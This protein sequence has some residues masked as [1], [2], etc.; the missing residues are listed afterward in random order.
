MNVQCVGSWGNF[1]D[2][3]MSPHLDKA[4]Q[5]FDNLIMWD[6]LYSGR[7][8]GKDPDAGKDWGQ[9]EKGMTEDEMVG[10]HHWHN[11]YEFEQT[12][13][14][15]EG[16]GSLVCC[17]PWG[18][19]ESD[20][21]SDWTATATTLVGGLPLPGKGALVAKNSPAN[22]GDAGLI[23]GLEDP[24]EEE[25]AP[26]SSILAWKIPWAEEP[27]GLQS[28]GS[29]ESDMT[30]WDTHTHTHTHTHTPP[31]GKGYEF[32][33][34]RYTQFLVIKLSFL[35][36][37]PKP[38]PLPQNTQNEYLTFT[39]IASYQKN[40]FMVQ[41]IL[42]RVYDLMVFSSHILHCP[43]IASLREHWDYFLERTAK[44]PN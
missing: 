21:S 17:S 33:K 6:P 44:V 24:L 10:W 30:E 20:R 9:E 23:P 29:K 27:G 42:Q 18:Q 15:S 7:F 36:I 25:V 22:E 43:G 1:W 26:H 39:D 4:N 16:Q 28:M 38:V 8:I 41:D 40:H 19:K 13:G 3:E 32:S 37:V 14:D 5:L 12:P 2:H 31:P 35:P 34:P 11:G